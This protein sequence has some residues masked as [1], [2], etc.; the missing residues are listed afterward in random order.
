MPNVVAEAAELIG[1][2]EVRLVSLMD[3]PPGQRQFRDAEKLRTYY[4]GKAGGLTDAALDVLFDQRR[5]YAAR[6]SA[7]KYRDLVDLARR[8]G[9]RLASHDDTTL[10]HVEQSVADRVSI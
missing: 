5:D 8:H 6:H 1:R 4:R 3:H 7:S 10:E 2:P 9:R